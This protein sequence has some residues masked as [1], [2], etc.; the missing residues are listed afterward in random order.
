L[1]EALTQPDRDPDRS[2]LHLLED[3]QR[4]TIVG[5]EAPSLVI[6]SSIWIGRPDA[7]IRFDLPAGVSSGGTDLR[8]TL[9]V[10]EPAPEDS[11]VGYMRERLNQLINANLRFTFGQ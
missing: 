7:T 8:W 9:L 6:W 10:D 5:E 4:P 2:W 3:E 1:F 11:L